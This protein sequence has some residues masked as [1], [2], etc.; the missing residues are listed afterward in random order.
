MLSYKAPCSLESYTIAWISALPVE[1]AAAEAML[2]EEHTVPTSFIRH[3]SDANI[4][5]WGRIG[6]H[7]I[8]IVSSS[9]S[10]FGLMSSAITAS[11]LLASLPTI[12]IGL[13]VGIGSGIAKPDQDIRLGDVVV[14]QPSGISGGVRQYDFIK[15]KSNGRSERLGFLGRPPIVL[16]NA[17]GEIQA[18]HERK[19]SKITSY[20]QEMLEKNPKMASKDKNDTDYSYQG[21]END[22]LHKATSH[23][24]YGADCCAEVQRD[25]RDTT[26]PKIHYGTIASGQMP[27]NN[28]QIRDRIFAEL[29]EDCLCFETAAAGL[30]NH[31]PC[32]VIRGICDYADS[33]SNDKWH[34]YASATAA[35]YAKEILQHVPATEVQE[36]KKTLEVLQSGSSQSSFRKSHKHI[37]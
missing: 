34:K 11:S 28:A 32:L 13:L 29:G 24:T 1:R 14:S 26:N 5:T 20:L 4:Y 35:A 36:T 19:D 18:E 27:V 23:P 2:D 9:S 30:M 7:N 12:S 16:L 8:V 17:L 3:E 21:V 6:K 33:H 25:Y 37:N 15:A 31:F 10:S 22:V